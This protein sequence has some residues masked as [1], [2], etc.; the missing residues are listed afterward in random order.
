MFSTRMGYIGPRKKPTRE[1]AI[2][3]SQRECT[4][5]T[6]SSKLAKERDQ[7]SYEY[8]GAE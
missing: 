8:K 3:F 5:Q 1:I 7:D 2:A 6:V 4:S